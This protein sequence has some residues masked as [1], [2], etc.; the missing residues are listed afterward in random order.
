[1]AQTELYF[2]RLL[3]WPDMSREDLQ[4]GMPLFS[5]HGE[6][7]PEEAEKEMKRTRDT[8]YRTFG[9]RRSDSTGKKEVRVLYVAEPYSTE[10]YKQDRQ[11]YLAAKGYANEKEYLVANGYVDEETV[12]EDAMEEDDMNGDD[13]EEREEVD[14]SAEL[15]QNFQ[16]T[17]IKHLNGLDEGEM[18][19]QVKGFTVPSEM[20]RKRCVDQIDTM[21]VDTDSP[22]SSDSGG[23]SVTT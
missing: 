17:N 2:T 1:M 10:E 22:D 15:R 8:W 19:N 20:S 21:D 9:N 6:K 14:M 3:H 5:M 18:P 23:V 13:E 4:K 12:E 16:D 7:I 11:R